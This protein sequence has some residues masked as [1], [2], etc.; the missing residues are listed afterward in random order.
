MN[1]R[2]KI[3]QAMGVPSFPQHLNDGKVPSYAQYAR[4]RKT[5]W[6]EKDQ[7]KVQ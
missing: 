7:A 3:Y 1:L 6:K 4:K 2:V 5:P